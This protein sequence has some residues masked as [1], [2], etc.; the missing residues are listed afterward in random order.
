MNSL[1][2]SEPL[3]FLSASI[4]TLLFI[5]S[6]LV[7]LLGGDHGHG[8]AGAGA[9]LGDASGVDGSLA[10]HVGDASVVHGPVDAHV[11]DAPAAGGSADAHHLDSAASFK[12]FTTQSILAFFM[13]FGWLGLA[14]R[15]EWQLPYVISVG[16]AFAFAVG[17]M[18]F[19]AY[20]MSQVYRL[21][22][23]RTR[24]LYRALGDEA[25][26][27]LTIPEN[28]VGKVQAVVDGSLKTVD[29]VS[30]S[31]RIEQFKDV[32]IVGVEDQSTLIVR[33]K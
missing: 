11:G 3:F 9:D 22:A 4:S 8:D 20:L 5:G 14:C 23:V 16:I 31:G 32:E 26:V 18:F 25:K 33:E 2:Q 17:L 24:N 28:G 19:T 1:L 10:A 27:Y 7:L 12:I 29:A 21:N 15:T 30:K 6:F 13:G